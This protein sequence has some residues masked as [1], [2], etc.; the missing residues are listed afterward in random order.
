MDRW[1][2]YLTLFVA[3]LALIGTL[4]VVVS[5]LLG[6][7]LTARFLLKALVVFSIAGVVFGH[8]LGRMRQQET[9]RTS[10]LS[11]SAL[12]ARVGVVAAVLTAVLG[13]WLSGTPGSARAQQFDVQRVEHL[14]RIRFAIEKY[15]R[16]NDA[17][18]SV[19][20]DLDTMPVGLRSDE[21]ADPKSQEPYAYT[22][23][24]SVR[25]ELCATFD[26]ATPDVQRGRAAG[27]TGGRGVLAAPGRAA[28]LRA[29]G[30]APARPHGTL[31]PHRR[32]YSSTIARRM[33][34]CSP[35]RSRRK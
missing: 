14:T 26:Q 31:S 6:G 29:Q 15:Y 5:G 32:F 3:A 1:L 21:L 8:H 18:P 22:L 25:Y 4:V 9:E 19:M 13:L 30:A 28:L 27:V 16:E 7:E 12:S 35:W 23:I 10:G 34:D 17:L 24:D 20:Q 33:I 2:T 11:W